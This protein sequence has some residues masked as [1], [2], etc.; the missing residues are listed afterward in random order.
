[1]EHGSHKTSEDASC[2]RARIDADKRVAVSVQF[3]LFRC[4][5]F[6]FTPTIAA[7]NKNNYTKHDVTMDTSTE[8]ALYANSCFTFITGEVGENGSDGLDNLLSDMLR[9]DGLML[10]RRTDG[11]REPEPKFN[12]GE[13]V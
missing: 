12:P 4:T 6:S 3:I 8:Y 10:G 2:T 9:L 13:A 7:T 5:L 1:V 11:G